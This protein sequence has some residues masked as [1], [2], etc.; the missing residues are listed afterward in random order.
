MATSIE[1]ECMVLNTEMPL[2]EV[3]A[4]EQEDATEMRGNPNECCGFMPEITNLYLVTWQ[5]STTLRCHM[6]ETKRLMLR[7]NM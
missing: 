6:A 1:P 2:T 3:E 5:A 4:L 7:L